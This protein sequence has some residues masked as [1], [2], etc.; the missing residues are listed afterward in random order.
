MTLTFS[1]QTHNQRFVLSGNITCLITSEQSEESSY[2]QSYMGRL[3]NI[4]KSFFK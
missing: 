3:D 1:L 2:Y 4:K